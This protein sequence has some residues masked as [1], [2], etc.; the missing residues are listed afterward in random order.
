MSESN[1]IRFLV[2]PQTHVRSTEGDSVLFRI[3][4]ECPKHCGLPR[5]SG[6]QPL[7]TAIDNKTGKPKQV[8][9][10]CPHMLSQE[11]LDRKKRIDRYNNYKLEVSTYAKK[12]RF[13]LPSYG[14]SL[15]F[16]LPIAPS[17]KSK[18]K[19]AAMHGLIHDKRV[20]IDNFTKAFFDSLMKEDS[21]VGQLSG[22][23]KFWVDVPEGQGWIEV[24][25]NQPIYDPFNKY[26]VTKELVFS[27]PVKKE[28][29]REEWLKAARIPLS[30]LLAPP[31]DMKV[32]GVIV[33]SSRVN[34]NKLLESDRYD[35]PKID[36]GNRDEFPQYASVDV[37]D[38]SAM[39]KI[40][41]LHSKR[42][43]KR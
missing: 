15:Y 42:K 40:K 3:P 26:S 17:I 35:A 23:G 11:G 39:D 9:Y 25:I 30:D 41:K 22:L 12:L 37:N 6:K 19:R 21:R 24:H 32:N 2:S 33:P 18:K 27:A 43:K 36:I 4:E 29:E 13:T 5:R 20:D 8:R 38:K 7:I 14:F 16:F 1:I 10:G 28:S 34:Y 31:I